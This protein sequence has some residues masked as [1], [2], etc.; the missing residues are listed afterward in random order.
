MHVLRVMCVL[1]VVLGM[2]VQAALRDVM[3]PRVEVVMGDDG[4]APELEIVEEGEGEGSRL[5]VS[6][7]PLIVQLAQVWPLNRN[8]K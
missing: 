7:V 2:G 3:L 8:E 4:E 6:Q 5:D 1:C